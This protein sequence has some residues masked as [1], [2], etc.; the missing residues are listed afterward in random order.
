MQKLC[1]FDF[2]QGFGSIWKDLEGFGRI[3]KLA[4]MDDLVGLETVQPFNCADDLVRT[5]ELVR[6]SSFSTCLKNLMEIIYN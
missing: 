2:Y 5:D 6:L 4:G 1:F 3:W